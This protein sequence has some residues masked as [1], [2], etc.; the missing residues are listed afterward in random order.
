MKLRKLY[1]LIKKTYYEKRKDSILY[2]FF[3]LIP[4]LLVSLHLFLRNTSD[5]YSLEIYNN[6]SEHDKIDLN[7]SI[8]QYVLFLSNQ[9]C[10]REIGDNVYV[11][12][13]CLT[14]DDHLSRAFLS[15]ATQNDLNVFRVYRSEEECL[16]NLKY[17]IQLKESDF[18]NTSRKHNG[19][20]LGENLSPLVHSF[21]NNLKRGNSI[22]LEELY[23]DVH[24]QNEYDTLLKLRIDE[25]TLREVKKTELYKSFIRDIKKLKDES[26]HNAFFKDDRKKLFF[27]NFVKNNLIETNKACGMLGIEN[28][29]HLGQQNRLRF[30]Y[31]FG[32]KP[33][34]RPAGAAKGGENEASCTDDTNLVKKAIYNN[35]TSIEKLIN[36]NDMAMTIGETNHEAILQS[37][38]DVITNV[39]YKIRVG[40]YALLTSSENYFFN[41]I[42]INLKQN[43]V[44][45]NTVDDLSLNVYFNEWYYSS[46][47]IVLE[48]HFNLFMLKYNA[49]M[50]GHT[51][52]RHTA[53][54]T[55]TATVTGT[56]R[57]TDADTTPS[58]TWLHLNDFF[59]LNMPMRSMKINAFDTIEKNIFRMVMFLCVCLFIVNICFDINKERKIKME[60]FL[61]CLKINKYYYYFSWLL[62]YF[63]VLFFYNTFFSYVIY[64]YVYKRMVNFFFLFLYMYMFIVNSL[65]FT[66]MCMHFSEN[67]AINY[68][69]S[70]LIFFL[71]SSFRLIIH[72][73]V[74]P[75]LSFFVLLIPHAS[76]C[77]ALDFIFILVKNGIHINYAEMFIKF[78][79][80]SLM[81]LLFYSVFSFILL[82]CI[83]TYMIHY[84]NRRQGKL[85]LKRGSSHQMQTRGRTGSGK[86]DCYM[87]E[88]TGGAPE[89]SQQQQQHHTSQRKKNQVALRAARATQLGRHR[90]TTKKDHSPDCYLVIKNV[91]KTYGRKHVLKNVSLTLRSNRIFVLLGENGSGKST[92]IN[93]ITEMIT[94]D[95]GEIHFVKRGPNTL[96]IS[97]HR[98]QKGLSPLQ[99]L[100]GRTKP[101]SNHE[102][103]ISYCSQNVI[104]Y[105]NLTFYETIVI[106]LLYYNKDVDKFLNKKR[107]RKI[108]NDLDLEKYLN[109][110]IKNLIDDVKKKISI[111][112][113]FLVKRDVYIL[114]E[115][116]IALDIKTKTKLFKFF[117]KIK[118]NNIIF[119]CTHDIYEANNF[120]NDIAVIKSGEIIFNGTKRQFQKLIDYKFVLNVRFSD[121]GGAYSQNGDNHMGVIQ[122]VSDNVDSSQSVNNLFEFLTDP[123]AANNN[124][125][126]IKQNIIHFVKSVREENKTCFIFF[127][128]SHMYCTYKIEETES[129]KKL[130]YVL[131]RFRNILT[132]ELKT[133]DIYYTYIYIYT[134]HEKKRLLKN[135]QH[136]DLRNLIKMDPLFYL[137]F[138]NVRYFNELNSK[139]A[140]LDRPPPPAAA[141]AS[142]HWSY[143]RD[144]LIKGTDGNGDNCGKGTQQME[145]MYNYT[146]GMTKPTYEAQNKKPHM[147]KR[148]ANF[149]CTYVKPTLFLKIKKDLCNT[150]FYWVKFLV[151]IFLLSFGLLIIKCVSLFGKIENIELDYTTISSNHLKKSTLNYYII[152]T[153]DMDPDAGRQS[154]ADSQSFSPQGQVTSKWENKWHGGKW[155]N[156]KGN[157]INHIKNTSPLQNGSRSD[158]ES[159]VTTN[160]FNYYNSTINS[161]LE[162][163][164]INENINYIDEQINEENM[165]EHVHKYLSKRSTQQKDI[166]LGT[167]IF[168]INEKRTNNGDEDYNTDVEVN[169]NLFCNYTSIHSYAYYTNSAFNVLTEFQSAMQRSGGERL[170]GVGSSSKWEDIGKAPPTT[171]VSPPRRNKIDVIN[172]PFPIKFH[173]YFLRDFY[174]NMYVFLSIVIFFCVFFE[175]LRNEIDNRKIFENFNVHKYVHYLQILL[176]EYMYYLI[177][178]ILLFSV[179]YLFQYREFVL[180]SFFVFLMMYGF[181]T[182]LS[183]S[184]FSHLYQHSYIL[185]VFVNFILCGIISIVI[186]VLVILSY[187]YNNEVLMNLSHIFVC[188]F[189][190]LDSFSLSHVLNIRSLCL[191]MKRHMQQIDDELIRDTTGSYFGQNIHR[192][193][194]YGNYRNMLF[195]RG[196]GEDTLGGMEETDALKGFCSD[197]NSF[198]NT[199]GDFFFLIVNCALY[200]LLIF[201]KLYNLNQNARRGEESSEAKS[202]AAGESINQWADQDPIEKPSDVQSSI[203]DESSDSAGNPGSTQKYAFAVRHFYLT[204]SEYKREERTEKNG[205]FKL[206]TFASR[207]FKLPQRTV[208]TDT[209]RK[210][211]EEISETNTKAIFAIPDGK[212]KEAS[213]GEGSSDEGIH[214]RGSSSEGQPPP[215][216]HPSGGLHVDQ[217]YILKDINVKMKPYKIYTFSSIFN[218][219]LNVL[220]FFKFFFANGQ[221]WRRERIGG[222]ATDHHAAGERPKD[223]RTD[224]KRKAFA[225]TTETEDESDYKIVLIPHMTI[226][227]HIKLILTY[228]NIVL[229]NAELMYVI[230]LLMLTVNLRCDVHINCNEL[231]GGMRKKVELIINLLRND[232]IIFLY[233]LNDNIDFCSQ[234]YI[235]IILKNVLLMNKQTDRCEEDDNNKMEYLLREQMSQWVTH[236]AERTKSLL[237][238]QV[239]LAFTRNKEQTEECPI[240]SNIQSVNEGIIN[241]FIKDNILRINFAPR[242]FAIYT[243][244]YTDIFYYDYL[245]LFNQN[246]ITYEN[247]TQNMVRGFQDHYSFLVK[248]KGIDHA[249]INEYIKVFFCTNKRACVRFCKV[250]KAL[251]ERNSNR[252]RNGSKSR[253]SSRNSSRSNDRS[254]KRSHNRSSDTDDARAHAAISFV[255]NNSKKN[256][257]NLY[258]LFRIFKTF[259]IYELAYQNIQQFVQRCKSV[260]RIYSEMTLSNQCLF[261]LKIPDN[262]HFFK[263]LE[264]NQRIKFDDK[265][266]Q[267]Q[268][269]DI[270]NLNAND[271]FL[272]LF[273]KLL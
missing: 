258:N 13:I 26:S 272:L 61:F 121:V 180:P 170:N 96:G 25:G 237:N 140:I 241:A 64:V 63:I 112:I 224:D 55:G 14:P 82:T 160:S 32:K 189:R 106:F 264:I 107:T 85:Y 222:H 7:D 190:I 88:L 251:A 65:L 48:Y 229:S 98:R 240:S 161:L 235:N 165:Y 8:R 11:N 66:V 83:L 60:N 119:I 199:T 94:K 182:F 215:H 12:H 201:Y 46:F 125:E 145:K 166:S 185:F 204:N 80:I 188:I 99:R 29:S 238:H 269:V 67:N 35:D 259:A 136:K 4:F 219:D 133:I 103:E 148:V 202:E 41:D 89:H 2:F 10:S 256:A 51:S 153:S 28:V 252:N 9:L 151:P 273:K 137:F 207:I 211:N 120:A 124:P 37:E 18:A 111:F 234:I 118:K 164:C 123:N 200:L 216:E 108:M 249:K 38:K 126:T 15:Y 213:T 5:K 19:E 177:Y 44:N 139:L 175:K 265:E 50:A 92:L 195:S 270:N 226:Y 54:G 205:L 193:Q 70:F 69:A 36:H 257:L 42:N 127:N 97:G 236:Y 30:S 56:A 192:A 113:C 71:F 75:V 172:E 27:F 6:F 115:P 174:I 72:S 49:Q 253:N 74:G 158:N 171:P 40:D 91:N 84:R 81:H 221:A 109:H 23:R 187:A 163:Y 267:V 271:I 43:F 114:D 87:V 77:L 17:A 93:I 173:E 59:L 223:D 198:F 128:S 220:Y 131:K 122:N 20:N 134:Y 239:G 194:S 34:G 135:V 250:M 95:S 244:I 178:I 167:Y 184:L 254:N 33:S 183:I 90:P 110:K 155:K 138:D 260:K 230:N 191:N 141:P 147:I 62:F 247:Y 168:Q 209:Y 266:I 228:K 105:D 210:F 162:K 86:G 116:F 57:H 176:L 142:P 102:I 24:P 255:E 262:K 73:G 104:L 39:S 212:G 52:S 47:F 169:V 68:I 143:L 150:S 218:N 243:H 156:K 149:L 78:E 144:I 217:K 181:N 245:Y 76:F 179:L 3:L 203:D 268:Q 231:S 159:D 1:G 233:K 225:Q 261:I 16:Q 146:N 31:V 100:M 157:Q 132:Y 206:F 79:N 242:S 129:L 232:P 227:E 101:Q 214:S 45:F 58:G 208:A 130:L 53:T 117:E 186:Y 248:L 21:K 263:L 197:S 154:S 246:E 152:Y 196:G 22:T